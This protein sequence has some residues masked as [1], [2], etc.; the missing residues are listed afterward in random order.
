MGLRI[1]R[2]VSL[3]FVQNR[4]FSTGTRAR[5]ISFSTFVMYNENRLSHILMRKSPPNQVGLPQGAFCMG[6][7]WRWQVRRLREKVEGWTVDRADS[8]LCACIRQ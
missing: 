5:P 4:E 2:C 7:Y 8:A 6:T 3:K 1:G